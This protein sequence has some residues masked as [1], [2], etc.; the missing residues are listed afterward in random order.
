LLALAAVALVGAILVNARTGRDRRRDVPLAVAGA[1]LVYIGL[2]WHGSVFEPGRHAMPAAV[3]VRLGLIA[4]LA[5]VLDRALST[6][7]RMPPEVSR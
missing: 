2:S 3:G 4:L 1:A 7:D 5:V 6:R